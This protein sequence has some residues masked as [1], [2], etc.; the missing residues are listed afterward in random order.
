MAVLAISGAAVIAAR[1]RL[2]GR[3]AAG[4]RVGLLAFENALGPLLS[5]WAQAAMLPSIRKIDGKG[6][7]CLECPQNRASGGLTTNNSSSSCLPG[8]AVG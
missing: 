2:V 8:C 6:R 5:S 1:T 7:E 4:D 3:G